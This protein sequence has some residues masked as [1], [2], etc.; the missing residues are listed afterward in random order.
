MPTYEQEGQFANDYRNLT[1]QQRIAFL[2]A[3]RQVVADLRAKRG[4]RPSLRIKGVQGH[5]GIFEMTWEM[6]DGRATFRYGSEQRPGEP[7]IIWR[8]VGGHDIF[9]NP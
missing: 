6:A 4:F 7:H 9:R 5:G 2:T 8:R 3:V 1:P